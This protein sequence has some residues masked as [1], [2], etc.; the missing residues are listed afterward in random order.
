VLY[1]KEVAGVGLNNIT[2][3]EYSD[4]WYTDEA[5]AR[6]AISL[7]NPDP[8]SSIML[9]FDTEQSQFAKLLPKLGHS[10][11]FGVRD[12]LE[13][14]YAYDCLITN[15]PFSIKDAVI[16]KVLRDGRKATLIL[17]LDSLGGVKR[18]QL[19][20]QYGYP[21]VYIP[22]RRIAYYDQQGLSLIHI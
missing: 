6:L 2:G 12:W 19:F 16:E 5:T 14:E 3:N 15:P 9:P 1:S 17:P 4:E 21:H 11:T 13:S 10:V 8:K 7:L 22:T 18:H 20:A